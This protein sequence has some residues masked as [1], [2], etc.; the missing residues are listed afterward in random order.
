[1]P[2]RSIRTICMLALLVFVSVLSPNAAAAPPADGPANDNFANAQLLDGPM[3]NTTGSNVGATKEDWEPNHAGVPGGASIWFS[4]TAPADGDMVFDTQGSD[5]DTVLAV[6]TGSPLIEVGSNDDASFDLRTSQVTFSGLGGVMYYIAVDGYNGQSGNV[7]LNWAPA[8]P[9]AAQPVA[10]PTPDMSALPVP[11]TTCPAPQIALFNISPGEIKRGDS[12]TLNWGAVTNANSAVIDNGVGGVPTP[13]SRAV[14]PDRRTTYTITANGCAGTATAQVTIDV[15][16]QGPPDAGIPQ[17]RQ[18][19]S[20]PYRLEWNRRS[21][22]LYGI[23][24]DIDRSGSYQRFDSKE[25]IDSDH[26]DVRN[27]PGGEYRLRFRVW[28]IDPNTKQRVSLKGKYSVIC[29]PDN[30]KPCP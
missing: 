27:L 25:N 15:F 16:A 10:S 14:R 2:V 13:G 30:G 17:G 24:V 22:F 7:V 20:S 28:L 23:D 12:A 8:A 9:V 3:G 6:Y 29:F 19:R 11:P 26:Y 5:F 1:M 4:W 21:N 18:D